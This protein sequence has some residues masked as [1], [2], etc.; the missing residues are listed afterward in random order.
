MIG[1]WRVVAQP[2]MLI[3]FIVGEGA[4]Q[5][6]LLSDAQ[7]IDDVLYVIRSFLGNRMTVGS[8]TSMKRTN[9]YSNEF[10]QGSYSSRSV[11]TDARKGLAFNLALSLLNSQG[12]PVVHFA[13]EATHKR[14][15]SSVHGAVITGWRAANRVSQSG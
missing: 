11:D 6:E 7:V 9:W 12:K 1:I 15:Y 3:I 2:K 13:G 14:F 5:M 4:R 10:F 8:P